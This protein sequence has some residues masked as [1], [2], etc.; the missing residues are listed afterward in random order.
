[1][2]LWEAVIRAGL[3]TLV[4]VAITSLYERRL[5]LFPVVPGVLSL[6]AGFFS[7]NATVGALTFLGLYVVLAMHYPMRSRQL[8][9]YEELWKDARARLDEIEAGHT[10]ETTDKD[11]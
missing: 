10:S 9:L 1:M 4:V 2:S 7:S 11:F 3:T 6:L 5:V 8:E